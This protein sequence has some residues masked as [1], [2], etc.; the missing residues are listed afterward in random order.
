MLAIV[1]VYIHKY[2][3]RVLH[4]HVRIVFL[5]NP[6]IAILH[7]ELKCLR[8]IFAGFSKCHC[9]TVVIL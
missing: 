6:A 7:E 1:N 5:S 3:P 9:F 8:G 4:R 2:G